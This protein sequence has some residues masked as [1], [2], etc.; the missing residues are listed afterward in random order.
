MHLRS[1][2]D[3]AYRSKSCNML[4]R[5]ELRSPGNIN[6]LFFSDTGHVAYPLHVDKL[7]QKVFELLSEIG[8]PYPCVGL[9]LQATG[10]MEDESAKTHDISKFF[11]PKQPSYRDREQ[12]QQPSPP[13]SKPAAQAAC[14]KIGLLAFYSKTTDANQ[15]AADLWTCP[16][17][18][19]KFPFLEKDEH[20]D[21]HFALELQQEER[22]G[23][24]FANSSSPAKCKTGKPLPDSKKPKKNL[25]FQPRS[26]CSSFF[27]FLSVFV[28]IVITI[29][30]TLRDTLVNIVDSLPLMLILFFILDFSKLQ[31][32]AML[33]YRALAFLRW[34]GLESKVQTHSPQS[35]TA[36]FRT[37]GYLW[38]TCSLWNSFKKDT[39]R[40][41][42]ADSCKE[43]QE[44]RQRL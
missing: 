15:D 26:W 44:R 16:K 9:S 29:D 20:N 10:M 31:L 25:F 23:L 3:T 43:A 17:C 37:H 8:D 34:K 38:E 14:S 18:L 40:A 42:S 13:T 11:A 30:T 4:S 6:L 32:A 7:T 22:N 28:L 33:A 27:L 24:S 35:W 5:G 21:Y 2:H 39:C 36:Y 1:T 12:Q 41:D 19:K